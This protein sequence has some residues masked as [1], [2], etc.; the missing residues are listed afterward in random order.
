MADQVIKKV[1]DDLEG[2]IQP[3]GARDEKLDLPTGASNDFSMEDTRI[4]RS[5]GQT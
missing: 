2:R 4:E 1:V 5:S 3:V